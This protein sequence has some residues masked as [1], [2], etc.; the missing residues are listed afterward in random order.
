MTPCVHPACMTFAEWEAWAEANDAA[1]SPVR[2]SSP[3]ADCP[4]AF[5]HAMH[6]ARR[7]D[8]ITATQT[9]AGTVLLLVPDATTTVR[10]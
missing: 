9:M 2:A 6:A 8:A 3:C 10:P 5:A 4:P 1:P 7:C